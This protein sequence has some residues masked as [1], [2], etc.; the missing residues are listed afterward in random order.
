MPGTTAL[1]VIA[2]DG[3]RRTSSSAASSRRSTCPCTT[4]LMCASGRAK[5]PNNAW[6]LLKMD[7]DYLK[8]ENDK[9]ER[10]ATH[11]KSVAH[12]LKVV[13]RHG[14]APRPMLHRR[15]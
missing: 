8:R 5:C 7:K 2:I 11:A 6:Q 4:S 1:T 15:S 13:H 10:E 14:P 3:S 9:L 12:E